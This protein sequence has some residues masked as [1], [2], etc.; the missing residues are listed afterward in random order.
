MSIQEPRKDRLDAVPWVAILVFVVVACGLAWAVASPL[1]VISQD[2]PGYKE[3]FSVIASA[4]MFTPLLAT[5]VVVFLMKTPRREWL[6]FLG[7]WPL[8]PAKR[9]VWFVVAMAFV[10]LLLTLATVAVAVAF[11]WLKLDLV[12]F[13]GF[14][15]VLDAQLQA[16]GPE[17]AQAAKSS[18]P[19]LG[20]L[21]V[22]QIAMIPFGALFNAAFAFGEEVGWRGWLLPALRP[23]GVWPALVLSGVIWGVWHSPVILLGYNFNRTD[24]WGVVLMIVGCVAWG[25]FFGWLRLRTASLWP[26]VIAHGGLNAS[27]AIFMML[28]AANPTPEIWLVSPLGAA[29]WIVLGVVTLVLIVTGQFKREP[30]LAASK[31]PLVVAQT[32]EQAATQNP[33]EAR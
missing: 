15:Q 10:P 32:V 26:A 9:V 18:M 6:R 28:A 8:R 33:G 7:V 11:G 25:V 27:G 24:V 13:S 19:P 12:N 4:M 31:Q 21:V 30:Q 23:L 1:W 29:G 22:L 2:R 16:L 3:L 14:A 5:L 17:A 20:L